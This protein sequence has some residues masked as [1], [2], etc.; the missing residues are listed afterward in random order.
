MTVPSVPASK[1]KESHWS[2]FDG[3]GI[4]RLLAAEDTHFWFRARNQTIAAMAESPIQ[5]LG[6]GFRILEIG[7]GSGNVLRVLNGLAAG[8]GSVE[9]LEVSREAAAAARQRTGLTVID[10]YLADLPPDAAFDVIAAFD[11]LE[12]IADEAGVLGEIKDRLKP[13][14]R[15]ILT[16]PAHQSLWS[17]FDVASGHER[18]YTLASLSRALRASG[19]QVEY[20]TYFMSL[21]FPLMWVRRRLM[22]SGD[23]DMGALLDS[24]FQI[25]PGLNGLAYEVL[26]QEAH[27]VRARRRLP[28]GASIAAIAVPT[29]R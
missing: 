5:R 25:V 3:E 27:V 7:C 11:V 26:R 13:D 15:L 28:M 21:L 20:A 8:R 1:Q 4:R 12:H 6:D 23:R 10:G 17:A 14:G 24:E 19:F 9:G 2:A 18:R 22:K 29:S 16:V